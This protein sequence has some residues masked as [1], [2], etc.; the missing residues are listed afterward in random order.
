M[1]RIYYRLS[2]SAVCALAAYGAPVWFLEDRARVGYLLGG[3]GAALL[4][5]LFLVG[6]IAAEPRLPAVMQGAVGA[7]LGA[8]SWG[9]I[10]LV[11][12]FSVV[13]HAL[14]HGLARFDPVWVMAGLSPLAVPAVAWRRVRRGRGEGFWPTLASSLFR[15]SVPLF[16][17]DLTARLLGLPKQY[18][19]LFLFTG[20]MFLVLDGLGTGDELPLQ[21]PS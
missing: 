9:T 10:S 7:G 15:F 4:A 13:P 1:T 20:V 3:L 8:L 17:L 6:A 12:V 18:P 19:W 16:G 14:Q 5:W 21:Y 11:A 2:L